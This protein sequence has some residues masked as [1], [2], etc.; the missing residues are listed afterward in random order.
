[1]LAG[2]RLILKLTKVGNIW[3]RD[4]IFEIY[5]ISQKQTATQVNA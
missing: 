1:M 4:A 3:E 5:I 2:C